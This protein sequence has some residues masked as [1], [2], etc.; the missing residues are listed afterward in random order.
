MSCC[1][2]KMFKKLSCSP[3]GQKSLNYDFFLTRKNWYLDILS[4]ENHLMKYRCAIRFW[5]GFGNFNF[6]PEFKKMNCLSGGSVGNNNF[7]TQ[8]KKKK[9]ETHLTR[10]LSKTT[11]VLPANSTCSVHVSLSK[12]H[13]LVTFFIILFFKHQLH[14]LIYLISYITR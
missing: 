1:F 7:C 2:A 12:D 8:K 9:K 5:K 4:V 11:N 3:R 6:V 10:E 13:L 14:Y